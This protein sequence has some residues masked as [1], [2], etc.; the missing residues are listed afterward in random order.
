[1]EKQVLVYEFK[2]LRLGQMSKALEKLPCKMRVVEREEYGMP[3]G[4]LAGLEKS[5]LQESGMKEK[6]WSRKW[7]YSPVLWERISVW[8]L[9]RFANMDWREW[10]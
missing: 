2:G 4:Y 5:L 3:L 10:G 9:R 7:W 8:P 1:M 6:G